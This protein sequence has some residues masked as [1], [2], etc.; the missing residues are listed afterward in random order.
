MALRHRDV[1]EATE[2]GGRRMRTGVGA[3]DESDGWNGRGPSSRCPSTPACPSAASSSGG[4]WTRSPLT[5][6]SEAA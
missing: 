6:G 5:T 4:P 1:L 2:H 3:S